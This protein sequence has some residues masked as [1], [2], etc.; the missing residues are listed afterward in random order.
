MPVTRTSPV[1]TAVGLATFLAVLAG[2]LPVAAQSAAMRAEFGRPCSAVRSGEAELVRLETQTNSGDTA[3][4][5]GLLMR[6][7]GV[8]PFP[9][10]V[11]LHT[12]RGMEPPD[13]YAPTQR[14]F[15]DWG[16]ASLLLD[17]A[18]GGAPGNG[19]RY[20][21]SQFE[22]IA[23]ANHAA[24]YLA[25][26][27]DID[28]DQL[29]LAGWS[30]GATATLNTLAG[31][32]GQASAGNEASAAPRY[33]AGVAYYPMCLGALENAAAPIIVLHGDGDRTAPVDNCRAMQ[34]AGSDPQPYLYVEFPGA[35]HRFDR[36]L[37]DNYLPGAA[38][39]SF[40]RMRDFLGRHTP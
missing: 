9:A 11:M 33:R 27:P 5:E 40:D 36:P 2:S 37:D 12:A 16:Y 15:R 35:R 25:T 32:W 39:E 38:E 6:P 23:D 21:V 10:I 22:L 30:R 13:C 7:D 14:R 26:R 8:G 34:P 31:P 19:R 18:S 3:T 24:A 4:I 29:V 1:A 17:P 20:E 28:V